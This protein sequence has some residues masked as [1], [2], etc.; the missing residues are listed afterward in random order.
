[1]FYSLND[2]EYDVDIYTQR[3]RSRYENMSLFDKL[4]SDIG[5]RSN[6]I[7]R[8]VVLT[9]SVFV[10]GHNSVFANSMITFEPFNLETSYS[11]RR[12]VARQRS[13]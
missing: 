5:N 3:V 9:L 13:R 1:V 2:A 4:F 7:R 8:D 12:C 10:V 11:V 6:R